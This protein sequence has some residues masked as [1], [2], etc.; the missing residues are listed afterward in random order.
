MANERK[1]NVF[2]VPVV[3]NVGVVQKAGPFPT[4]PSE[5]KTNLVPGIDDVSDF[6]LSQQTALFRSRAIAGGHSTLSIN[7]D[8]QIPDTYNDFGK[9]FKKLPFDGESLTPTFVDASQKV[10][11]GEDDVVYNKNLEEDYRV[12]NNIY[13]GREDEI[14]SNG[15]YVEGGLPNGNTF[16]QTIPDDKDGLSTEIPEDFPIYEKYVGFGL[17]KNRFT[18][19]NERSR[20]LDVRR[21]FQDT[22]GVFKPQDAQFSLSVKEAGIISQFYA[23]RARQVPV[24][25]NKLVDITGIAN[26]AGTI[27]PL[28]DIE[29]ILPEL[30]EIVDGSKNLQDDLI[31]INPNKTSYGQTYDSSY[32]FDGPIPL[33]NALLTITSVLLLEASLLAFSSAAAGLDMANVNSAINDAFGFSPTDP[34]TGR[35]ALGNS[36]SDFSLSPSSKILGSASVFLDKD[37]SKD[38]I[39]GIRILFF[40]EN[41][42]NSISGILSDNIKQLT[43]VADNHTFYFGMVKNITRDISEVSKLISTTAT[44]SPNEFIEKASEVFSKIIDSKFFRLCVILASIG[45]TLNVENTYDETGLADDNRLVHNARSRSRNGMDHAGLPGLYHIPEYMLGAGNNYV[46]VNPVELTALEDKRNGLTDSRIKNE[47]ITK[48]DVEK[49]ERTLD[50]EY[51][52]FSIQDMRTNDVLAFHAFID[53][54]SMKFDIGIEGID[55]YGRMEDILIHKG[56]KRS[57]SV[58]FNVIAFNPLDFDHMW[59]KI[60]RLGTMIYPQ[61]TAGEDIGPQYPGLKRPF[62]QVP[63]ASPL[64]RIALGDVFTRNY[65]RFNLANLFGDRQVS[66]NATLKNRGNTQKQYVILPG[67]YLLK[68]EFGD[69]GTYT[70][71][72]VRITGEAFANKTLGDN[73]DYYEVVATIENGLAIGP[74]D[75]RTVRIRVPEGRAIQRLVVK[76]DNTDDPSSESNSNLEEKNKIVYPNF[77]NGTKSN[78]GQATNFLYKAF[79]DNAPGRGLLGMISSFNI[80]MGPQDFRWDIEPGRRAPMHVKISLEMKIIEEIAPGLDESGAMRAPIFPVGKTIR[81]MFQMD[82]MQDQNKQLSNNFKNPEQQSAQAYSNRLMNTTRKK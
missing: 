77:G 29:Q 25:T 76:Y 73:T 33:A 61:W 80:D 60:N 53:D 64:V 56:T 79:E 32:K 26:I 47:K 55:T 19:E 12:G 51:M 35:P 63:G 40:G 7:E 6:A 28:V 37:F 38:L 4:Q 13:Q 68:E 21:Y 62:S 69:L 24:D 31:E 70:R 17:K 42:Q 74:N 11:F 14:V 30:K 39:A 46:G 41:S 71:K 45:R 82:K 54:V 2:G 66:T 49:V 18:P 81:N 72:T 44:S 9:G 67:E 65:S 20:A 52:N 10:T 15:K 36:G 57:M 59:Y 23:R 48:E 34:D 50:S 3:Q 22:P 58:S 5:P 43:F 1:V 27:S 8:P 16:Y 78:S 75:Q